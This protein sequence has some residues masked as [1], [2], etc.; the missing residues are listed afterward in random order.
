MK[1]RRYG[2]RDKMSRQTGWL[3]C[4]SECSPFSPVLPVGLSLCTPP[5]TTPSRR[6][7]HGW[8]RPGDPRHRRRFGYRCFL[9]DL[10]GFTEAALRG[11]RVLIAARAGQ[12]L[13]DEAAG[14]ELA[15]T[16]ADCGFREPPVPRLAQR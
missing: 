9:S 10:A 1:K 2:R 15:P 6:Y 4:C 7:P 12:S 16:K 5:L 3:I 8:L 13:H 11:T 14:R